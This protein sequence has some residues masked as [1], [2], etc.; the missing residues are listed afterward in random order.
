[1]TGGARVAKP[2]GSPTETVTPSLPAGDQGQ[3]PTP[4]GADAMG[5]G[6]RDA[7]P[8]GASDV[9]TVQVVE[10]PHRE[11]VADIAQFAEVVLHGVVVVQ[12]PVD[13][14]RGGVEQLR[15]LPVTIA[16]TSGGIRINLR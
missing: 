5:H 1:M 15:K 10:R 3:G 8:V 13:Q 11:Q 2:C 16:P 4:A 12:L 9:A 14:H 6:R 7:S